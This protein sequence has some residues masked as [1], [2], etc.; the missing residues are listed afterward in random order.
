MTEHH[1]VGTRPFVVSFEA[2]LLPDVVTAT[3][4]QTRGDDPGP[5]YR[6]DWTGTQDAVGAVAVFA[7]AARKLRCVCGE[8]LHRHTF[9]A[10]GRVVRV[11]G[12]AQNDCA[13]FIAERVIGFEHRREVTARACACG[14]R[15][16]TKCH[17]VQE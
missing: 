8:F 2:T 13:G 15:T 1:A 16:H 9:D 4:H 10:I 14:S 12:A 5:I 3:V 6:K 7:M 11:V 17:R